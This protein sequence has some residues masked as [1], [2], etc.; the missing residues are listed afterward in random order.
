MNHFSWTLWFTLLALNVADVW[1]TGEVFKLGG[2]EAN[3]LLTNNLLLIILPKLAV[4]TIIF[5]LL[6]R[7]EDKVWV[8][9]GLLATVVIY[10]FVVGTN[11]GTIV[12]Y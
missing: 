4:L 5:V 7:N 2:Y 1:T 12:A 8:P 9:Y 11:I 6:R 10:A 3:P